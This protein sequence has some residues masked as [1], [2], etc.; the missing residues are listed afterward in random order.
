MC[1]ICLA[2]GTL[3]DAPGGPLPVE[4]LRIGAPVWTLDAHGQRVRGRVI[5]VGSAA[6]PAD[7][8]VVRLVL[9]DGRTAT[10]SPGHPLADGRHLGDLRA[11]DAVDGSVVVSADLMANDGARTYDLAVSGPTG[12]YLVDGIAMGSTLRP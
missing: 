12:V 2:G 9:A 6:A 7:H 3:I 11:G 4:G 8:R 1:P 5:A 10:A